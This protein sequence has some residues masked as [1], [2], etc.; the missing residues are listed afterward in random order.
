[1]FSITY[2]TRA[3]FASFICVFCVYL[4]NNFKN[5]KHV[6]SFYDAC[7]LSLSFSFSAVYLPKCF[8]HN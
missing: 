7:G 2:R 5:T 4:G 1:M 3:R 8:I 6:D